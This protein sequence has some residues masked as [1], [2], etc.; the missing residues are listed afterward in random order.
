MV[1]KPN[2]T[3]SSYSKRKKK[4]KKKV[5]QILVSSIAF[6]KLDWFYK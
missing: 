1:D 2:Q 4:R 6:N 5:D 3:N